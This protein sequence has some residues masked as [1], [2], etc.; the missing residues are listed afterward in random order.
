VRAPCRVCW[1]S[2]ALT[3]RGNVW[4]HGAPVLWDGR[5]PRCLGS[6]HRPYGEPGPEWDLLPEVL[7]AR[8]RVLSAGYPGGT[9]Y[10]LHFAEPFQHARH[11]CGWASD[12]PGRL[13]HHAAGTGAN[14]LRH[15]AKAG[16][17]WELARTWPGDRYLERRIK[18]RGGL[19]RVCPVCR[20]ELAE[21][22]LAAPASI[23]S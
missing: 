1:R 10:L 9:V 8:L 15:V 14:L 12:L 6:G 21:R 18:R 13:A 2:S 7:T 20:P 22:L 11:Y 4:T 5:R 23:L 19:R 17:G 3:R 16:I